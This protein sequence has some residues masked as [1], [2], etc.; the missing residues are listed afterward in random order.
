MLFLE[1]FVIKFVFEMSI[2]GSLLVFVDS[3]V[4]LGT[5]T[6]DVLLIMKLGILNTIFTLKPR[7]K[8][9]GPLVNQL[10]KI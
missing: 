10:F 9:N 5:V 7:F 8:I 6:C 4:T 3:I 2:F 1:A